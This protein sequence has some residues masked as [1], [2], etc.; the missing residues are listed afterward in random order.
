M[1]D[2]RISRRRLVASMAATVPLEFAAR[3]RAAVGSDP[4]VTAAE[5]EGTLRL[6]GPPIQPYR[7]ALLR[8]GKTYPNIRVDFFGAS[9]PDIEARLHN[10]RRVGQFLWDVIVSGFSGSVFSTQLAAA[11]YAPLRP[12]I[13][14]PDVIDDSKWLG[15][16]DAGFLDTQK[17]FL[18]AFQAG[19]QNNLDIDRA[20]V[21]HDNFNSLEN[22]F[23]PHWKGRIAILDPRER[24]SGHL[25]TLLL[26]VFGPDRARSFLVNQ[27]PVLASSNR[28]L[29]DWMATGAY[30]ITSGLSPSEVAQLQ[31]TGLATKVEA[32]QTPPEY[33]AWTPGWGTV[34]LINQAPHPSSARLFVNWLLSQDEQVN[35]AKL[36]LV[37]SRRTD[38]PVGLQTSALDETSFRHGLT[39]NN[40]ANANVALQALA[41]AKDALG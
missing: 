35:W 3:A 32:L 4:M 37:N 22:L 2:S 41:I 12:L 26:Y 31:A 36:G 8:F 25:I 5:A 16:F 15:G 17:Q 24:G 20:Q 21:P 38:V 6:L 27:R 11:W 19:K 28:Q 39:F 23:D 1:T 34:G 33:T 9:A 7:E 14:R 29:S 18:Y 10:E 40:Q 13:T 30:P